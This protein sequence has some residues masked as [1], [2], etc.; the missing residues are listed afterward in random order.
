MEKLT[1][2]DFFGA[3]RIVA[4]TERGVRYKTGEW[5]KLDRG[6]QRDQNGDYHGGGF[7]CLRNQ[8]GSFW[9]PSL[10]EQ[11]EKC[12]EVEPEKP[13]KPKEVFVWGSIDQHGGYLICEKKEGSPVMD[14]APN[15]L[16]TRYA[17]KYRLVPADQPEKL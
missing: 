15:S 13:E 2:L 16:F 5:S 9:W 11:K 12:W 17:T 10:D 6:M 7:G 8:N 14:V 4:G 1:E 3:S